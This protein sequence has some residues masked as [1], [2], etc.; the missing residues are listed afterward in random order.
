MAGESYEK[1]LYKL[2]DRIEEE[3]EAAMLDLTNEV[4]EAIG[5]VY[6]DYEPEASSDENFYAAMGAREAL[7]AVAKN[8]N[9][10][11]E[12]IRKEWRS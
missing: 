12:S 2:R 8:L 6:D 4:S 7:Y 10:D 9:I 11:P 3:L 1:R 5:A